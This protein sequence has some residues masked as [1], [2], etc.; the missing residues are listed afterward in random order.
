MLKLW[1]WKSDGTLKLLIKIKQIRQNLRDI[2]FEHCRVKQEK[3]SVKQV[4][5]A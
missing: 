5:K 1:T 4:E 3:K 2:L